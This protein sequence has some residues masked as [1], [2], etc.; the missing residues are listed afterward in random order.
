MSE[1]F[2]HVERLIGRAV[3]DRDGTRIG[4]IEEMRAARV[5]SD[6]L[7]TEFHVGSAALLER[8]SVLAVRLSPLAAKRHAWGRGY[9]V[10]WDQLDLTDPAHPRLRCAV[11]ELRGL[12][13]V[14]EDDDAVVPVDAPDAGVSTDDG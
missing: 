10:P 8:L 1:R 12:D 3:V 13:T 4:R 6:V 2:L 9:R 14:P 11:R 7:V 5:G